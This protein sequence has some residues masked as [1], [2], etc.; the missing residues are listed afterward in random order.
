MSD[1]LR[2]A[3]LF[4][5]AFFLKRFQYLS[6]ITT[7]D[8]YKTAKALFTMALAHVGKEYLYRILYYDCL[9]I[10]KRVHNPISG[11]SINFAKSKQAKFRLAFFEELKK[12]RK[13]A[14]RLGK[15]KTR[16]N[17][18]INPKT[19]KDLLNGR[20]SIEDIN[21]N[22][23][24][25]ELHQKQVDIKIGLDVASLAYKKLVDKIILISG[26]SDFVPAAKLARREGID[27]VLDP[28]WNHVEPGLFEHIDGLASTFNDFPK[29]KKPK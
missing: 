11:A 17:W 25:F 16:N 19:T 14:I 12:K 7:L 9:P 4:D 29:P 20:L 1:Y 6:R 8:P 5:G 18:I 21:E 24:Y 10:L 3:V 23:V 15:L 22:D 28:M 26:D 13:L 27:F 2:I